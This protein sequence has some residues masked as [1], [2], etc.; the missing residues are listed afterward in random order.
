M[1]YI[2]RAI[3]NTITSL[4]L[5]LGCAAVA[6]ALRGRIDF[7]VYC[8]FAAAVC[9]FL[10]GLSARLLNAY[11]ELGKQLDSLADVVSFGVAPAALL[12]VQLTI[13]LEN[14]IMGACCSGFAWELLTFAPFV[15]TVFSA[16]RLAKFN[17]DTKQ[18]DN[19]IGLPTPANAL[20]IGAVISLH[21]LCSWPVLLLMC[22]FSSFMLVCKLPMFSLKFKSNY[23]LPIAFL[24]LCLAIALYAVVFGQGIMLAV[25]L[26]F[27][28]YILLSFLVFIFKRK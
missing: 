24:L 25:A 27:S 19:F 2:L 8:I 3:P 18:T 11:S 7:A 5:L 12:H 28:C 4:N 21:W 26:I 13:L 17:I 14:K 22:G 6:L 23:K 20:L 9:D 10:D 1:K 16:L 15:I